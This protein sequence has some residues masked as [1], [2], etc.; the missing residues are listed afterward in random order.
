MEIATK[1]RGCLVGIMSD[2]FALSDI[3]IYKINMYN[4][5]LGLME[6][7]AGPDLRVLSASDRWIPV[8][9]WLDRH[10]ESLDR[11]AMTRAGRA[12]HFRRLPSNSSEGLQEIQGFG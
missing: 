4:Y 2:K 7:P 3:I 5:G 6:S 8:L 9:G 10:P 1:R 12:T 11:A